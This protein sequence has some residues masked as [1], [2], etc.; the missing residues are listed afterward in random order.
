[1][2]EA[3]VKV[4]AVE[5]NI[6]LSAPQT[7]DSIPVVAGD[8]VLAPAQ[9]TQAQNGIYAVGAGAWV[10]DADLP[11]GTIFKQAQGRPRYT[12][13]FWRYIGTQEYRNQPTRKKKGRSK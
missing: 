5:G 2:P 11:V 4:A 7:I 1:M 6:T 12:K 8:K 9:T 13:G 10:K 3:T